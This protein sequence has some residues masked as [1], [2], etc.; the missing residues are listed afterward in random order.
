[1][2][3]N[4]TIVE[5]ESVSNSSGGRPPVGQDYGTGRAGLLF[6]IIDV[7]SILAASYRS[8]FIIASILAAALAAGIIV[9]LLMTPQY[10]A[11]ATVQID[12]EAAKGL[13]TE[14]SAASASIA[15][16]DRFLQTQLDVVRSRTVAVRVAEDL[17]LFPGTEFLERMG[18]NGDLEGNSILSADEILREEVLRT[19]SENLSVSLPLRSRIMTIA[20]TSPDPVLA[21]E[22]AN[23]F[24][25]N[26]IRSNLE[27]KFE[28]SAYAREFLRSQL[29]ESVA[30]L[31]ESEQRALDYARATRLV[32]TSNSG[33]SDDPSG[34]PKS[35]TVASL[36]QLNRSLGDA[37][38]RR[39]SAQEEWEQISG[40]PLLSIAPVLENQAIQRLLE[41]RAKV[42]AAY[43]EQLQT[44]K[45]DFPSV[46]RLRAQ[47]AELD[48]QITEIASGIRS[49]IRSKYL[50]AQQQE[51]ALEQKI[52]EL[53]SEALE[54]QSKSVELGILQRQVAT[55]REAY[56]LL[57]Q[58]Y[59]E[60][61]AEAGAQ[62][63]NVTL[64]DLA[65]TPDVPYSPQPLFNLMIA[66]GLGVVIAASVVLVREQVFD[67]V[68]TLADVREKLR[69]HP[70]GAIPL[71]KDG[72]VDASEAAQDTKTDIAEAYASVRASLLLSTSHGLP[73][74]IMFTSATGSEGKSTSC[75]A[76]ALAL[77]RIGKKVLIMDLDLRRPQQH[78]F[79]EARSE[80]G[81]ADVL[82]SNLDIESVTHESSFTNISYITSGAIPPNPT[83]LLSSGNLLHVLSQ[84]QQRYD[85]VLIDA[86]PV[87]A[88]A[89]ALEISSSVEA[90]IFVIES[91]KNTTHALQNALQRVSDASNMM[92]GVL[93]TKFD[94]KQSGYAYDY[95]YHYQYEESK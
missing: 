5:H 71:A 46:R 79:F 80:G 7:Q 43:N 10:L 20:F 81:M 3:T 44:R 51:Q 34:G 31:A 58:R 22:V 18:A 66:L 85:V 17:S 15:D 78:R 82:T 67:R 64:L 27:R 94:A 25:E 76:I 11:T 60:L 40:A 69:R 72:E 56:D 30:K 92:L 35:L 47:L 48:A 19:L 65:T 57:L 28:T 77:G 9:T 14:E 55:N 62:T 32:D 90:T 29:D 59:S 61:N 86:P 45:S 23:S 53:K 63:N 21:E 89:D 39:I 54:D 37:V 87:L 70:L 49:G 75:F 16:S 83:E 41:E 12:Q 91:S 73:K 26:Y 95:T 84:L 4:A 52:G 50:S 1:M 8:R 2:S 24:A 42:E 38:D 88:L 93:L 36:V 74:S 68:R 13:G 33:S 6:G